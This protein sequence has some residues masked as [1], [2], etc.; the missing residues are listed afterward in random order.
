MTAMR[1]P[2]GRP[3]VAARN[4]RTAGPGTRPRVRL[5]GRQVSCP[6]ARIVDVT[7]A[8]VRHVLSTAEMGIAQ[9]TQQR[10]S[11]NVR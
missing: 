10:G 6:R 9:E 3:V 2:A 11:R 4:T 8:V 5:L 7:L 1:L